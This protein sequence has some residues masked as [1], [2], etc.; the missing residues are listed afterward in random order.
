MHDINLKS[1]DDLHKLVYNLQFPLNDIHQTCV[2]SYA[3]VTRR[4]VEHC[5]QHANGAQLH[6][7][8]LPYRF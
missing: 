4:S 8:D 3:H 1:A 5:T 2:Y 7:T 6:F